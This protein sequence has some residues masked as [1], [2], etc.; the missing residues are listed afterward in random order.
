[1]QSILRIIVSEEAETNGPEKIYLYEWL[2][3]FLWQ[4]GFPGLTIRRTEMN[5]DQSSERHINI[6]EDQAFNDLAL[7]IETVSDSQQ[8]AAV[9]PKIRRQIAHGQVSVMKGMEQNDL[10]NHRYFSVKVY[11]KE[12]NT[13]FKKEE[14]EKVLNFFQSKNAFWTSVN[15]GI[16]GYGKDRVVH[17]QKMFSVSKQIPIVIEC[18]I[19]SEKVNELTAGL[20]DVVEEGAVFATPVHLIVNE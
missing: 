16:V 5:L 10:Q 18:L 17:R 1:M 11:T 19:S 14:Y 12:N 9:V 2:E 7:I 13:W 3:H 6:L 4:Q 20:K 15:K 8:I